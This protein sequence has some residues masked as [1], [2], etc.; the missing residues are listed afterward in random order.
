MIKKKRSGNRE[1]TRRFSPV[2]PCP[3][4]PCHR[5]RSEPRRC[6]I[7]HC[8]HP[9]DPAKHPSKFVVEKDCCGNILIQGK[10]L[11][12]QIWEIDVE[13]NINVAQ[14]SIYSNS[15]STDALEVEIDGAER[16]Y[17]YVPPGS[18]TNFIGQGIKSIKISS[19]GNELTYV[20]GR[21]VISTTFQLQA[22]SA[23]VNEQ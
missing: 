11:G 22:N 14:I 2:F 18:T 6:T 8:I 16:K 23:L 10:Q 1:R 19:Q 9:A 21:Y 12:F 5:Q 13:S 7:P 20:E 4:K 17:M 3:P 15:M